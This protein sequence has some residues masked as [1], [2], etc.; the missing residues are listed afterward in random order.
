MNYF[1]RSASL[2][3]AKE[4][5]ELYQNSFSEHILVFDGKLNNPEYIESELSNEKNL[6]IVAEK[7]KIIGTAVLQREDFIVGGELARFVVDKS[8]RN[9]GVSTKMIS[10]MIKKAE[11]KEMKYLFAHARG[12]EYGMQMCLK[13]HGFKP[14]GIMPIFYVNH[15][16]RR[17]REHFVYMDRFLNNGEKEIESDNNF[18]PEAKRLYE[19]IKS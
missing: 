17:I 11:E 19:I 15:E 6:W 8:M 18:I 9:N 7:D 13:K 4:I 2:I 3:D 5:A 16:G 12:P 1:I 14:S 10:Y